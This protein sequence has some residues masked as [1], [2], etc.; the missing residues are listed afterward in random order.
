MS[1]P[2]PPSASREALER[3][4]ALCNAHASLRTLGARLSFPD[5]ARVE[6]RV[7]RIAEGMRG[8]FG[9]PKIVNGGALSALCDLLIGF[10]SALVETGAPAATISLSIQFERALRGDVISGEAQLDRAT[11]RLIFASA[12]ISDGDGQVCV[13]CQGVVQRVGPRQR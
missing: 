1:S 12:T 11:S 8:G 10:T 6:I 3:Y 2:V 13:R 5:A 4:A 9:D 7:E